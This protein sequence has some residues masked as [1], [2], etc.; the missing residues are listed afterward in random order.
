MVRLTLIYF[1]DIIA[2]L[3]IF[4]SFFVIF[5]DRKLGRLFFYVRKTQ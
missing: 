4:D 3:F 2:L 1:C 5:S